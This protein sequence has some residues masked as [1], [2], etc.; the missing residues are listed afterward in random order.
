MKTIKTTKPKTT[1]SAAKVSTATPPAATRA[2]KQSL[3]TSPAKAGNAPSIAP[4]R[5]IT[6][7]LIAERAYILWEK[8]GRPPGHDVANWLLAESQLK[9]E[10]QSFTA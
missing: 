4:R 8:Q 5:E 2:P 6:S 7:D 1:K 9:Q 10:I 3:K